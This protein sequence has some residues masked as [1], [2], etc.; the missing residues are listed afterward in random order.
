MTPKRPP[1]LYRKCR[2]ELN[3]ALISL[4]QKMPFFVRRASAGMQAII[5]HTQGTPHPRVF[6]GRCPVAPNEG[7][8][9]FPHRAGPRLIRRQKKKVKVRKRQEQ[10]GGPKGTVA[11]TD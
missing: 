2:V 1:R 4:T 3:V 6:Y 5:V 10:A 8:S 11:L 7:A 9:R